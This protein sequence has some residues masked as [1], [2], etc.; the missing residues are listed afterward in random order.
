MKD[1]AFFAM[2][3]GFVLAALG[4]DAWGWFLFA[5]VVLGVFA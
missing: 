3:C 1:I 4:N 5:T 2:L